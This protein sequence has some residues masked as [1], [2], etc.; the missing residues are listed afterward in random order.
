[1]AELPHRSFSYSAE[2]VNGCLLSR[3][4]LVIAF[5]KEE[6]HELSKIEIWMKLSTST[7]LSRSYVVV[8]ENSLDCRRQL[9]YERARRTRSTRT[10][11]RLFLY[12]RRVVYT[13]RIQQGEPPTEN[14]S[15][16]AIELPEQTNHQENMPVFPD[17]WVF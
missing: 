9:T 8:I 4:L 10:S 3:K 15:K 11:V 2:R 14:G 16:P 6:Y 17:A 7:F 5:R 12:N 13:K 1:M